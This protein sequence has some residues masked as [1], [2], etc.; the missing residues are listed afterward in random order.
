MIRAILT[1]LVFLFCGCSG[2]KV[3]IV[4]R[5]GNGIQSEQKQFT[6]DNS[7]VTFVGRGYN[8]SGTQV[9][10]PIETLLIDPS[11]RKKG[12]NPDTAS[13]IHEIPH[14]IYAQD[15]SI[16]IDSEEDV[17]A[18]EQPPAYSALEVTQ[19]MSGEYQIQVFGKEV[20]E[21]ELSVRG[22]T[23]DAELRLEQKYFGLTEKGRIAEFRLNFNKTPGSVSTVTKTVTFQS[24]RDDLRLARQLGYIDNDGILNSLNKKLENAEKQYNENQKGAANNILE[25]LKNELEAQKG[26][27]LFES[28]GNVL[29][30]DVSE[31]QKNL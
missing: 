4:S 28:L 25:A 8:M 10:P 11:G 3:E 30:N 7:G 19:P 22:H 27:H 14:A 6:P 31:L 12:Y 5:I 16:G 26:K 20:G 1:G 13:L 9:D 17:P 29:N 24:L 18:S 15:D 23:S 2:R 21:Y